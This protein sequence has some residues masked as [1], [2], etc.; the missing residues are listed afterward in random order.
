MAITI[1]RTTDGREYENAN[2]ARQHQDYVDGLTPYDYG[3]G[4]AENVYFYNQLVNHFNAGNWDGVIKIYDKYKGNFSYT[5]SYTPHAERLWNIAVA[6]KTNNCYLAFKAG[7]FGKQFN[8]T[9]LKEICRIAMET[10]N[11]I[12]KKL[13]GHEISEAEFKTLNNKFAEEEQELQVKKSIRNCEIE[14]Y[15]LLRAENDSWEFDGVTINRNAEIR[16][17]IS[18]W[19]EYSKRKM[20][21]EDEINIHKQ[22]FPSGIRSTSSSKGGGILIKLGIAAAIIYVLYQVLSFFGVLPF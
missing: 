18:K 3:D 9:K 7:D 20:T 1:Y 13:N 11:R 10:G 16:K 22:P 21:T 14:I 6:N 2:R 19:E 5:S 12:Y 15:R 4:I 17:E 8:D